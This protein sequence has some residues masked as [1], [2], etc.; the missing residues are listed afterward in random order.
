MTCDINALRSE[1]ATCTAVRW[2][3]DLKQS[4]T[5]LKIVS[6]IEERL[7]SRFSNGLVSRKV[8]YSFECN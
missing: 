6:V 4:N 7:L 2:A 8:D 5:A 3:T 1:A